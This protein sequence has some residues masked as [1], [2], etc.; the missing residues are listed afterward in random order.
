MTREEFVARWD[1]RR[2]AFQQ[3]SA[4]VDGAKLCAEVLADFRAVTNAQGDWTLSLTEAAAR[5]GYSAA[6]LGRLLRRGTIPNAG[7][8]GAPRIRVADLP[9]RPRA[10]LAGQ[11]PK[12]YDPAT[13]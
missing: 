6:H 12:E 5:S 9:T 7:R 3:F 10:A 11:P 1:R 13:D 4:L 8:P 2:V